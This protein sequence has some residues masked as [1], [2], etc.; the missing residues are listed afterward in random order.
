MA[1]SCP[2]TASGAT[3][4]RPAAFQPAD[5]QS[6]YDVRTLFSDAIL[7]PAKRRIGLICPKL[8]NGEAVIRGGRFSSDAGAHPITAILRHKRY[9]EVWLQC[10]GRPASL[11]FA[12]GGRD[13]ETAGRSS[14]P[15]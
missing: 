15:R 14:C 12:Y 13:G 6:L 7:I 2:P 1:W 3:P 4:P 5:D 9:D 10:R 11:R 8:M